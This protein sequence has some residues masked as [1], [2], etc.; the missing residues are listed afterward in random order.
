[1]P[2]NDPH[3]QRL[4]ALALL[5]GADAGALLSMTELF[6]DRSAQADY[7]AAVRDAL[8]RLHRDGVRAALAHALARGE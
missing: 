8:A 1:M 7:V 2:I 4:R 5:G 6:G 3:A